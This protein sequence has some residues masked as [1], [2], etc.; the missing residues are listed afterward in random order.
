MGDTGQKYR[1]LLKLAYLFVRNNHIRFAFD[2][3][4]TVATNLTM[5]SSIL[6]HFFRYVFRQ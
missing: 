3:Y 5:I 1:R 2:T 4:L 6:R